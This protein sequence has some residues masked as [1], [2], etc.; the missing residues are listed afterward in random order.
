MHNVGPFAVALAFWLFLAAAAVTGIVADYQKRRVALE[1][2]RAAIERG[3]Q[4]DPAVC[5]RPISGI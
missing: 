4:L 5:N 3:Q 2:L 1:T